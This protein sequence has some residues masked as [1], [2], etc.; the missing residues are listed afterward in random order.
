MPFR[1]SCLKLPAQVMCQTRVVRK[2]LDFPVFSTLRSEKSRKL[3]EIVETLDQ[4]VE[5]HTSPAQGRIF[6]NNVSMGVPGLLSGAGEIRERIRSRKTADPDS[7][8][9]YSAREPAR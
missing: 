1:I 2:R 5:L 7:P 4:K 6:H 3:D 9:A 8:S